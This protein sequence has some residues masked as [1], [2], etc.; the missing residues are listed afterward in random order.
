MRRAGVLLVGVLLPTLACGKR[1][2]PSECQQLLDHYV[3]ILLRDDR[4]GSS[5]A[6]VLRIQQEARRKA[7]TDPAFK[8]CSDR[9]SRRSFECAMQAQDSRSVEMCLL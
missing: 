3:E 1:V 2:E 7:E 8:E 5:A 4:P 9:V 6:E